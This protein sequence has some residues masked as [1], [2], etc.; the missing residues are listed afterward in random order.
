MKN[1]SNESDTGGNRPGDR[2]TGQR[3][4][5]VGLGEALWDVLPGGKVLGGAPL[6]VACHAHHLLR[7]GGGAAIVASR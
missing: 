6:N 4:T 2:V 5:I 1:S 3:F 7:D